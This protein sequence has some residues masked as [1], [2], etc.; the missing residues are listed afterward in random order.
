M[1]AISIPDKVGGSD[2]TG[3]ATTTAGVISDTS[4]ATE[5]IAAACLRTTITGG[6]CV[7]GATLAR[8]VFMEGSTIMTLRCILAVHLVCIDSGGKAAILL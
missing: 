4:G 5:L 7:S 3:S 6:A 2:V 8:A 1:S